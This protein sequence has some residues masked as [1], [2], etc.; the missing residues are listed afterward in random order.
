MGLSP[1][2]IAFESGFAV[3]WMIKK[4]IQGDPLL[5]FDSTQGQAV[6]PFISWGPY[7]WIDGNNPRSDQLT[8]NHEDMAPDCTHP[9]RLGS[10]KVANMLLDFFKNDET[11][12]PW[13]LNEY[14]ITP[15][16]PPTDQFEAFIPILQKNWLIDLLPHLHRFNIVH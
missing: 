10:A 14:Q 13:F 5:N 12:Q 11:T 2:P 4:Q 15:T 6:V 3:K 8:W 16:P 7:L 1:E 9:S